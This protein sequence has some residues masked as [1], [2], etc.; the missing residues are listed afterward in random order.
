MAD[1]LT[2]FSDPPLLCTSAVSPGEPQGRFVGMPHH[3]RAGG[4]HRGA[5]KLQPV[6]AVAA[7]YFT[8]VSD[9]HLLCIGAVNP[10]EDPICV[11]A[12]ATDHPRR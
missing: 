7:D 5:F 4:V 11:S 2:I 12:V 10:G 8:S 1:Y 3:M 6:S 9:Q